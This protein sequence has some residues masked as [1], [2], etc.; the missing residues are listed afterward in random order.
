MNGELPKPPRGFKSWTE[1]YLA[2]REKGLLKE[3]FAYLE[4]KLAPFA[5]SYASDFASIYCE[6]ILVD[7]VKEKCLEEITQLNVLTNNDLDLLLRALF[8]SSI[9]RAIQ[10]NDLVDKLKKLLRLR[11]DLGFYE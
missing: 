5:A 6:K 9:F 3:K 8:E 1:V 10:G 11:Y 2:L 7:E 4:P